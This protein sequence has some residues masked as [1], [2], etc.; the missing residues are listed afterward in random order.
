MLTTMYLLPENATSVT[1][2]CMVVHNVMLHR[3]GGQP[4]PE[5][6]REEE[7]GELIPGAWRTEALMQEVTDLGR[8]PR[9]TAAGKLQQ[10]T[11]KHY[12]MS[13]AGSV[14]WQLLAIDR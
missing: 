1:K 12:F 4:I 10:A 9:A 5:A 11:L 7:D 13:P 2:A 6:D 14:P 3:N 8:A